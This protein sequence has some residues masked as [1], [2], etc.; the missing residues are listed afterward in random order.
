VDVA[1]DDKH[2]DCQ[3]FQMESK[4]DALTF[5]DEDNAFTSTE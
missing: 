5:K 3:T 1:V 4:Q 2:A